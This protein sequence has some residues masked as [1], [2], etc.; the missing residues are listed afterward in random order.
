MVTQ[1]AM[2]TVCGQAALML[3]AAACDWR[4]LLEIEETLWPLAAELAGA[5]AEWSMRSDDRRAVRRAKAD[6]RLLRCC[7]SWVHLHAYDALESE[8][9]NQL[10]VAL[11]AATDALDLLDQSHHCTPVPEPIR[12]PIPMTRAASS[13]GP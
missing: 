12:V 2:W 5:T 7:L 6:V 10:H 3:D 13:P 8:L 4:R 9:Q 11:H 1:E